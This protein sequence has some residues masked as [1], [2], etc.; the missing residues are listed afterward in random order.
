MT[1]RIIK[2]P[3]ERR[4]A[5]LGIEID[6]FADGDHGWVS[7]NDEEWGFCSREAAAQAALDLQSE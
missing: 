6:E 5:L 4:A 3:L 1:K 7:D 2:G